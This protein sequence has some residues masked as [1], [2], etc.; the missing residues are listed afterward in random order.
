MKKALYIIILLLLPAYGFAEKTLSETVHHI[1]NDKTIDEPYK[2]FH[3]A[4][5]KIYEHI[6]DLPFDEIM[7]SY[8]EILLPFVEKNVKDG[9]K[10]NKA[11]ALTYLDIT[12]IYL[13]RTDS[14]R[15]DYGEQNIKK[16]IEFAE[17]SEDIEV[18]AKVYNLYGWLL[19]AAKSV[20]L[21][22]EYYYKAMNC[23]EALNDYE[24]I[25]RCLF[26][27]AE[28][29]LQTRDHV[30]LRKLIDQMQQYIKEPSFNESFSCYHGLYTLQNA[31]YG[32]HIENHPEITAYHD[33]A[34]IACRNMIYLIENKM[35]QQLYVSVAFS[36]YNVAVNYNRSCPDQYDSI[37]YF[38]NKALEVSRNDNEK[39][40]AL[41]VE[42]SVYLLYADLHFAQKKYA[43]A[44]KDILYAL[45]LLEQMKDCNTVVGELTEAYKVLTK[46]YEA[47]N[48]PDE[49]LKYH[50]LLLQ[51]EQKRYD[52]DKIVTMNDMLA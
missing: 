44:E 11:K 52:N 14:E 46:L 23:Y 13:N 21:A 15:Y 32:L 34:L 37:V 29:F 5:D 38:L 27:I 36:Y 19:S 39:S 2:R 47:M 16:A 25:F 41:E 50:K 10:R 49:A 1:L 4:L 51:N 28:N 12:T 43:Q 17:L 9:K 26:R 31:Y 35:E 7:S 42:I 18:C 22:H 3:I 45:S 48:R 6:H 8:K 20:Q 24:G 33:S 30:G 40:V